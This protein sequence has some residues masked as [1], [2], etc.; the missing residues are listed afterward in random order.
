MYFV[1]SW[2]ISASNPTWSQIDER[3]RSC[4][5]GYQSLRPVN[6]FYMV[7][8]SNGDQHRTILAALQNVAGNSSVKVDL[9]MSPLLTVTGW[10]GWLQP[11][12]W[13]KVAEITN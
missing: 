2:D 5:A 9:I 10:D 8:V 3:L 6:T 12:V 13:P 1:V 4:L 11:D 7:R